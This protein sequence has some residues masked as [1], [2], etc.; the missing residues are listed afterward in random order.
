MPP[1]HVV[2]NAEIINLWDQGLSYGLIGIALHI[3]RSQVAG[4]IFRARHRGQTVAR[5]KSGNRKLMVNIDNLPKWRPRA[6]YL[7]TVDSGERREAPL[8]SLSLELPS[9]ACIQWHQADGC[10]YLLNSDA[11]AP[12]WCNAKTAPNQAWCPYHLKKAYRPG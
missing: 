3:N 8:E 5:S 6:L 7:K 2:R 11:V 4:V 10:S 12:Q 1:T 9:G